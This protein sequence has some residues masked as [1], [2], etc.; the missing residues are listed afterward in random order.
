MHLLQLNDD[1]LDLIF[2]NLKMEDLLPLYTEIDIRFDEA[3]ERQLH[4]FRD[5]MFSMREPP[6][7]NENLM[8]LLGRQLRSL[9]I[10]VGYSTQEKKVLK[11]L[12]PLCQG[13]SETRRLRALKL[14]HVHW[15]HNIVAAVRKVIPSLSFLDLRQGQV[16]DD[17]IT[18]LLESADKLQALALFHLDLESLLEP[19][20]L[21]RMPSLTLVHLTTLWDLNVWDLSQQCPQISFFRRNLQTNEVEAYGPPAN[22]DG[23][24]YGQWTKDELYKLP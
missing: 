4:R 17:Q 2:A 16:N 1:C 7:F 20:I 9:H 11:Y 12:N 5:L 23:F 21:D 18:E 14:D 19:Q 15:S 10:N 6:V 13:A 24:Q 3:I 8:I 22:F